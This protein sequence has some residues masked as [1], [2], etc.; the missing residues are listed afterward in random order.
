MAIGRSRAGRAQFAFLD[1]GAV[2]ALPREQVLPR[3]DSYLRA[4]GPNKSVV[5]QALALEV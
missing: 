2:A 4:P 3:A 5:S 1:P